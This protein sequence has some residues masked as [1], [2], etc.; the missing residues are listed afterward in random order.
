MLSNSGAREDIWEP[1]G[2]QRSNQS[3]LREINAEIDAEITGR[4]DAETKGTILWTPDVKSW[5]TGKDPDAGKDWGQEE[6]G[7]AEDEMVG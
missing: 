4:T 3:I 5:I 2:Q 7:T 1:T 6:K